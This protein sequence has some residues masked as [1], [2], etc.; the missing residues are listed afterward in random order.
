FAPI[1]ET[2]DRRWREDEFLVARALTAGHTRIRV[3]IVPAAGATWSEFR[4]TAYSW[5]LPPLPP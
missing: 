2:V 5:T 4:Y 3:R 1:T